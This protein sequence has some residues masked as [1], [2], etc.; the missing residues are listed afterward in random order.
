MPSFMSNV[1]A[2]F[3]P[4]VFLAI[5]F[6]RKIVLLDP[7]LSGESSAECEQTCFM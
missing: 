2:F 4:F 1:D 6:A 3:D 5:V 7:A